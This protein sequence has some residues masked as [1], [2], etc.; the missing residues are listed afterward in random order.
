MKSVS[1]V[2]LNA[3]MSRNRFVIDESG[4]WVQHLVL[5]PVIERDLEYRRVKTGA[6]P[7]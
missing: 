2:A 1:L 6:S 3:L 5:S 4:F 7:F